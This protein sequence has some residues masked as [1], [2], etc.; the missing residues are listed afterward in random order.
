MLGIRDAVGTPW[1]PRSAP[2][3]LSADDQRAF[4]IVWEALSELERNYYRPERLDSQKLAA[5]AARAMVEAVGDPYTT[6]TSAEQ[7]ELTAAQLRGSFDGIGVEI[8]RRDGQLVV[9]APIAGSPAERAGM[10]SG[11]V[12]VSVDGVDVAPLSLELVSR[13]I[14]GPRGSS[15]QVGLRREGQPL[16]VDV[17]RDTIAI[18]SVRTRSLGGDARL[19]YVRIHTFGEPTSQQVREQLAPLL[20]EGSKGVVLDLRGNPG[21]YLSSAV[22]VTSIFL[23]DGVVLYQERGGPDAARRTYRTSGSPQVPD[24]PIAVLV[25]R[26]SASAAEIVAA[27]LRD[28]Q[29][30]V[31]IGEKTFGK[32]TVQE[33]RTLSDESQLRL[34]VAQWL[35]PSGHAIQGEGLLPDLE[36][37]V[38]DGRDAALDAAVEY[39]HG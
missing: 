13:R 28:N 22:D 29:R 33:L 25:D 20:A 16:V 3:A 5:A 17:V 19:A 14:R 11:D 23:K 38:V 18:A 8:D 6:L 30:A 12:I 7:G 36:V 9:V 26:G 24:L 32:G 15:V 1:Q 27:A 34:T 2:A 4:S 21:G 10:Q 31:L 35:T 39:L 37:P